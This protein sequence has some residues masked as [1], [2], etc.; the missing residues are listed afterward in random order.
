MDPG[1]YKHVVLGLIF[2][3]YISDAFELRYAVLA[4]TKNA[5]PED[6]DEYT[7]EN[8]FWVPKAA[9][10]GELQKAAKQP[11]IG[12]LIDK[13]MEAIEKENPALKSTLPKEYAKPSLDKTRLGKLVDT[14]S[15]IDLAAEGH[16]TKDVLGRAYEYFLK[17]FASAEGRLGGDFYTP[18]SVVRVLVEMI[19]PY[20][21]RVF[22]P[23]CGSGGMFVQSE[24]FVEAHGG[25][26]RDIAVH[27][28]EWNATTWRLC[29]MNLAIRGI[30]ANLGATWGDSFSLDQHKD[31]KADFVLANPPFNISDWGGELLR[32][33]ARWKYGV[34]PVG[35]ANFAWLQHIISHLSPDHGIGGVVLANG[36]MSSNQ[37]NEGVIRAAM[38]EGDVVD[39]MVALPGQLFYATGIPV[40][41]WFLARNKK[42]RRFRDRRG[43][44]LFIDARKMGSLVDRTHRELS[45]EDLAH[46]ATTYHAWRGEKSTGQYGDMPGFCKSATLEQIRAHGHVLTPGR[47]VGAAAAEDDDEPFEEKMVRFS[48]LLIEHFAEGARLENA[49]KKNLYG[50]D[51]LPMREQVETHVGS[52]GKR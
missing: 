20:K 18:Q 26:T 22:D 3:K 44:V 35:N 30:D 34:P 6:K 38:V 37:S 17:K 52:R 23:C 48:T 27:G 2:L 51:G 32:E 5:D 28:Q 13:A 45:D 11:E 39:C 25:S 15:D 31:L 7:A 46:I 9:R 43:E 10:W 14:V 16:N 24:K 12:T 33:D 21:G 42:D 8:V 1:E 47:Y 50:L 19:A 36:S 40:C 49:I 41:L 4:A 29:R